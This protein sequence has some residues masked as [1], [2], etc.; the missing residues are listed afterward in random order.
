MIKIMQTVSDE[1]KGDCM[2]AAIA[3]MLELDISQV[4]NFVLF[5]EDIW[6]PVFY[7]FMKSMGYEYKG[8][9]N[10]DC[11]FTRKNLINGCIYASVPSKNYQGAAHAV[12]INSK[13]RVIHDPHPNKKWLNKNILTTEESFSWFFIKRI[14]K[15]DND[16]KNNDN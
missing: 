11:E 8:T 7:N 4:P 6:F 13:G 9:M 12:L 15:E 14:P 10:R 5:D 2:R 3:S 16:T 1:R